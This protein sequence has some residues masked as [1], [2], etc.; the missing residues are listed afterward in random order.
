LLFAAVAAV[1]FLSCLPAASAQT[2]GV[3]DLSGCGG[4]GI[5]VTLSV[6]NFVANSLD[7]NHGCAITGAATNL[8]TGLG[9]VA[10]NVTGDILNLNVTNCAFFTTPGCVVPDFIHFASLTNLHFDLS[11]IGPGPASSGCTNSFD[12]D[13]PNCGVF[14]AAQANL[15]HD[16][17]FV[18]IATTTGTSAS[19][20]LFGQ[21][22][23]GTTITGSFIGTLTTQEVG[24]STAAFQ[25][26][27]LTGGLQASTYS[28]SI[29]VIPVPV[30]NAG[31]V[32][33]SASNQGTTISPGELVTIYGTNLSPVSS[34][35]QLLPI[36]PNGVVSPFGAGTAV[37]FNTTP[38]PL[39]YTSPTQVS[40]VVPYG[41]TGTVGVTVL[42]SLVVASNTV[43]V[44]VAATAP[45]I[46]TTGSGTGQ[47]NAVN[48]DGKPNG[49]ANPAAKGTIVTFFATGEGVTT[50]PG[51]DG[52]PTSLTNPPKPTAN[53]TVTIGGVTASAVALEAPGVV[54][55]VLQINATIPAGTVILRSNG[56]LNMWPRWPAEYAMRALSGVRRLRGAQGRPHRRA[57]G[58]AGA[59]RAAAERGDLVAV[60]PPRRRAGRTPA[61]AG[62]LG[63][64]MVPA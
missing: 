39:I 13:H 20:P 45:G 29:K 63:R 59:P 31:G 40:A 57:T 36:P 41:V 5:Q 52:V 38:A 18:L 60:A 10:G 19:L 21:V 8:T 53:V 46:F 50:P 33:N 58:A 28:L 7:A 25:Q 64:A 54:N 4:G 3:L 34:G 11:L 30:I 32:V 48:Q 1:V 43:P 26:K 47:I 62:N 61:G 24:T 42:Q 23:E 35:L 37:L 9:K 56:A 27:I 44:T 2:Q 12:P 17:P 16:S 49:A 51:A 15:A 14:T 6:V 55:G 22:R